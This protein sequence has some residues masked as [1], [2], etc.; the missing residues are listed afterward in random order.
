MAK[1]PNDRAEQLSDQP[2]TDI[3]LLLHQILLAKHRQVKYHVVLYH[4]KQVILKPQHVTLPNQL[5]RLSRINLHRLALTRKHILYHPQ[6][7][8]ILIRLKIRVYYPVQ[9]LQLQIAVLNI[10]HHQKMLVVIN[11]LL[12]LSLLHQTHYLRQ[13]TA[14]QRTFN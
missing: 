8:N 12:I 4:K 1:T 5:Q 6:R 13:I 2:T 10:V 7:L 3:V 14:T 9:Q 11:K